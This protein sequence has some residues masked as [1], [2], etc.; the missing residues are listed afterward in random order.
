MFE[1]SGRR[2]RTRISSHGGGPT[3]PGMTLARPQSAPSLAH[4]SGELTLHET[5]Y[6]DGYENCKDVYCCLIFIGTSSISAFLV[7]IFCSPV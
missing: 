6:F 2:G 7:V 5:V 4:R 1:S 3:S